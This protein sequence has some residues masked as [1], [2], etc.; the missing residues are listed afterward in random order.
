[1]IFL[2][3]L[4]FCPWLEGDP[5]STSQAAA[6]QKKQPISFLPWTQPVLFPTLVSYH[7]LAKYSRSATAVLPR[8]FN[9]TLE[10]TPGL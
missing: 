4:F 6:D 3:H 10:G 9:F 7:R 2:G 5:D 1:M 8:I